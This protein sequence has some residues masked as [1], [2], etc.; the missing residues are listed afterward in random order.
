VCVHVLLLLFQITPSVR[1]RR[2][3]SKNIKH[4]SSAVNNYVTVTDDDATVDANDNDVLNQDNIVTVNTPQE[5]NIDSQDPEK[6][7]ADSPEPNTNLSDL[8]EVEP[9]NSVAVEEHIVELE[10]PVHEKKLKVMIQIRPMTQT[11]HESDFEFEQNEQ[12]NDYLLSK[13]SLE[14]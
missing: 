4:V 2:R 8:S 10:A 12:T 13:Y 11:Y 6:S 3:V 14:E 1:R 7:K 5:P 9:E